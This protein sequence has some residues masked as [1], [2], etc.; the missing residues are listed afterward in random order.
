MDKETR[1]IGQGFLR[2]GDTYN[3]SANPVL[4][5]HIVTCYP[6]GM[7][8]PR[9][10]KS[11][12]NLTGEDAQSGSGHKVIPPEFRGGRAE[13]A[14]EGMPSLRSILTHFASAGFEA[15]TFCGSS[16]SSGT[17]A[18]WVEFNACPIAV[19]TPQD[20]EEE[21]A[22]SIWPTFYDVVVGT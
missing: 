11:S 22:I 13:S 14:G 3:E 1:R 16:G 17:R 5:E 6:V 18:C 9:P 2:L 19:C 4:L 8:I 20:F 12:S 15:L 10:G 21:I 7:T